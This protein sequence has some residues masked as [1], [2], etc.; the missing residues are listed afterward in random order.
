MSTSATRSWLKPAERPEII[1]TLIN[2][3]GESHQFL[4]MR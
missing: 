4:P 3:V 1:D 2:G